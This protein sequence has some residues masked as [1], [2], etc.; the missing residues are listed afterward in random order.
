MTHLQEHTRP[1]LWAR[2]TDWLTVWES[3]W[4][5]DLIISS[6]MPGQNIF[7]YLIFLI[8]DYRKVCSVRAPPLLLRYIYFSSLIFYWYSKQALA[9]SN[10]IISCSAWGL[11][12]ES[13]LRE[14]EQPWDSSTH[15]HAHSGQ[16]FYMPGIRMH[17]DTIQTWLL[18]SRSPHS[19]GEYNQTGE[20]HRVPQWVSTG[21]WGTEHGRAWC[22]QHGAW[23]GS[24]G[25]EGLN[26]HRAERE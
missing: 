1:G 4:S 3:R 7:F 9:G 10:N 26:E 15:C 8:P 12:K 16:Y 2:E 25:E 5:D 6:G 11:R 13:E 24:S 21:L 14:P 18:P 22:R 20:Q 17:T 19:S 23:E